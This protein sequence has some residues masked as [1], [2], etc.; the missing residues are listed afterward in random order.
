M[1]SLLQALP[2]LLQRMPKLAKLTQRLSK[3][4]MKMTSSNRL[5]MLMMYKTMPR[6]LKLRVSQ[7]KPPRNRTSVKTREIDG[8]CWSLNHL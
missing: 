5:R 6:V 7:S 1:R 4:Q 2:R 3:R 8:D